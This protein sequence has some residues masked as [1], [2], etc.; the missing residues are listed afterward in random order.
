MRVMFTSPL[1]RC[2]GGEALIFALFGG[3][4][5]NDSGLY[6]TNYGHFTTYTLLHTIVNVNDGC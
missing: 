1:D 5:T 4:G 3:Q 6:L 2:P